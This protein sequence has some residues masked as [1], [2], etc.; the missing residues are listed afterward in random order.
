MCLLGGTT[1]TATCDDILHVWDS[2]SCNLI[3]LFEEPLTSLPSPPLLARAAAS[4]YPSTS[5]SSSSLSPAFS[6]LDLPPHAIYDLP[7]APLNGASV[8]LHSHQGGVGSR[9]KSPGTRS[10]P[11]RYTCLLHLGPTSSHN[12]VAGTTAGGLR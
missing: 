4:S 8:P 5:A 3:A 11:A 6:R 10:L 12:L 2:T 1:L 9:P 7:P